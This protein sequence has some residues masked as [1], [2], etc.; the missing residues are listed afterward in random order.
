MI[1]IAIVGAFGKGRNL[2]NG[3]TIKTKII[4]TQLEKSYG[5]DQVLRIDTF[6]RYNNV[7]SMIK[8]VSALACCENLIMLPAHNALKVL[9]IWLGIWNKLFHRKLHYVVIGGWLDSYLD[10]YCLV[11]KALRE[12]CAIYVETQTMKRSLEKRGLTN[13]IVLPNC[14]NLNILGES[15]LS[16]PSAMP[17]KLV[18]FSRVMKRKGIEEL[19]SVITSINKEKKAEV[20]SLDIYGQIEIGE[21]EWFESVKNKYSLLEENSTI[22]YKGCAPYA[23][24]VEILSNYFALVFPTCFY[25]E[26]IPGT[27]IDAY[28]AG[29][30]VVSAKWESFEDVVEAGVTGLGF[31]FQDWKELKSVLLNISESPEIINNMRIQCLKRAEDFLPSKV[32]SFLKI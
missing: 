6:G 25:T 21:E 12:F 22:K 1:K 4:T 3:Q 27:I 8:C 31:A 17:F 11:E 13:I 10:K 20:F 7:V 30:P 23:Q 24:S 9:S 26:G 2:L 29:V 14:K 19:S 18:T 16:F 32:L 5:N 28:A 15:E